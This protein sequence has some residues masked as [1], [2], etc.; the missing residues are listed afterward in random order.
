MS[1]VLHQVIKDIKTFND[2]GDF[3]CLTAIITDATT[4]KKIRKLIDRE[5]KK[6]E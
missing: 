4:I 2:N 5:E 3:W 1:K 6:H